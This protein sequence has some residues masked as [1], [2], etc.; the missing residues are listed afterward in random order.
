VVEAVSDGHRAGTIYIGKGG[1]DMVVVQ[2]GG[3]ATV[4]SRPETRS[5]SGIRRWN[6]SGARPWSTTIRPGH[7][8]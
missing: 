3:K 4:I 1:A 6:C 2:R 8:L 5:F 7:G